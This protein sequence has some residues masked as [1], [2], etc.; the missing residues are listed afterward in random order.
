M[1]ASRRDQKNGHIDQLTWLR[2]F[3]AFLVIISHSLR[4]TEVAYAPGDNPSGFWFF[5]FLD[6]GTYGVLLF[7]VLSGCTLYISNAGRLSKAS[8][9]GFYL[10]RFLRIWPAFAVSLMCYWAYRYLFSSVYTFQQGHWVEKQFIQEFGGRDVFA[11]LTLSFNFTGPMGLFNNAF[12]SLPVE[13]QYYLIF[14]LLVFLVL[15]VHWFAPMIVGALLYLVP[16]LP[17]SFYNIDVFMLA[18][19]FCGGV[20]LG[21]FYETR[22][23]RIPKLVGGIGFVLVLIIV[24]A[25]RNGVISL[26]D[27]PFVANAVNWYS[28]FSLIAVFIVLFCPFRLHP[29]V[30]EWLEDYGTISY[31]V[32]LYHNLF[33]AT[34]VLVIIRYQIYNG[35]TRLGFVF[36]LAMTASWLAAK[37]SYAFVEKPC[38]DWGKRLF[39]RTEKMPRL[40]G[41]EIL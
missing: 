3:A 30:E 7:F 36:C 41:P 28:A 4:A 11:Y 20:I 37:I 13:F 35:P 27:M 32:Y 38:M 26:P 24:S 33:I 14:P 17:I 5:S 29:I 31:S 8:L 1:R 34:A 22:R 21:H 12:W 40:S 16:K 6:L 18:S 39:K 2:G 23:W 25:I 19:S 15:R 10:K 9:L